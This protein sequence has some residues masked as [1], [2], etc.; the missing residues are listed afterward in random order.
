LATG[1]SQ[2]GNVDKVNRFAAVLRVA[3]H[4][5]RVKVRVARGR[6]SD[7]KRKTEAPRLQS[8]FDGLSGA[9]TGFA[10]GRLVVARRGQLFL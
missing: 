4:T 7:G 6:G 1:P 9:R 5:Q 3:I 8:G 10:L 2:G